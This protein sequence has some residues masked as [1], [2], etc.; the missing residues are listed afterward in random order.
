VAVEPVENAQPPV[1]EWPPQWADETE[2]VDEAE[3]YWADASAKRVI[4]ELKK[5]ESHFFDAVNRRGFGDAWLGAFCAY[6]GLDPSASSWETQSITLDGERGELLRFRIN[7]F[8]SYQRQVSAMAVGERPSFQA[9]A[10]NTSY[11]SLAS[12][13]S[14]DTATNHLYWSTYG[15]SKERRTVEKG[16]LFGIGWTWVNFDPE[17]GEAVE[18]PLPLPPEAG[19]GDAPIGEPKPSGAIVIK[20]RA[21]WEVFQEFSTEDPEDH[22][23]RCVKDRVS[24]YELAATYPHLR[25]QIL[26]LKNDDDPTLKA[27][28][29]FDTLSVNPDE[30]IV[31]HFYHARTKALPKG[32]YLVYVGDLLLYQDFLPFKSIPLVPYCPAGYIGTSLGYADAWDMIPVC[33]LLDQ[34][35]SDLA[36]VIS[37]FGRPTLVAEDGIEIDLQAIADGMRVLRIPAGASPPTAANFAAVPDWTQFITGFLESK[38]QSLSGLNATSR[39]TPAPGVTS[40]TMA[41]LYHSVAQEINSYRQAAVDQHRERVANLLLDLVNTYVELPIMIEMVGVDERPY[42]ASITKQTFAGVKRVKIK[43]SN[44]MLRT[45]AGRLELAKMLL[46]VPGAVETPEQIVELVT[47]GQLKPMTEDARARLLRIRRENEDLMKGPPVALE[48]DASWQPDPLDPAAQ[49]PMLEI[50]PNVRTLA[51]CDHPIDHIHSHSATLG[52]TRDPKARA[53]LMAHIQEHVRDMRNM[54]PWLA[55]KLGFPMPPPPPG[56]PALVEGAEG[57]DDAPPGRTPVLTPK[58]KAQALGAGVDSTGVKL[59]RP[60]QPPSQFAGPQGQGVSNV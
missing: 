21:P 23:W 3:A 59:P 33:Q 11:D 50:V 2:D 52:A 53:A 49:Q 42:L 37:T 32:R 13:T 57:E 12:V 45:T 36:T 26:Q 35:A 60:A 39:G 55:E 7:E 14:A 30:L 46:T 15:E 17:G 31:K 29:G 28:F 47:S 51:I 58:G 34:V 19:G 25:S 38:M 56:M 44:P 43:T 1:P 5:K 16:D 4:D 6:Y 48:P 54:D 10:S 40:G 8:R 27:L 18:K 20:S 24:K 41:A 22:I 9:L